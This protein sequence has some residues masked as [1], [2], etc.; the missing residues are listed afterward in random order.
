MLGLKTLNQ[1]LRSAPMFTLTN[2]DL[3]LIERVLFEKSDILYRIADEKFKKGQTDVSA[4]E[5]QASK[6]EDV[7]EKI[8]HM[9][10]LYNIPVT[11]EDL[12]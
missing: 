2:T 7:L 10:E 3:E 8:G 5:L 1:K 11:S 12:F 6:I 4:L 9:I